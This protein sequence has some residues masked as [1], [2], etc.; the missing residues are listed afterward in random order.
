MP[1]GTPSRTWHRQVDRPYPGVPRPGDWVYL[2]E[3]DEGQGMF[4]TPITIVTWNN[5]GT[6]NLTF[7]L[8]DTAQAAQME[9]FGFTRDP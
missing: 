5:D 3:T 6:I 8:E 7:D 1:D 9:T 4:A 2:A